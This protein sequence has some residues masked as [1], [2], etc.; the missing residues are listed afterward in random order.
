M[1][2]IS[3]SAHDLEVERDGALVIP[4]DLTREAL[5]EKLAQ[6]TPWGGWRHEFLFSNGLKVSDIEQAKPWSAEPLNKLKI[7]ESQ[8]DLERFRGGRALDVGCNVGYNS[9]YLSR[10]YGMRVK[11]IDVTRNQIDVCRFF[12]EQTRC[13]GAEFQIA[14]AERFFEDG[15]FDLVVHFGTLYHLKNPVLALENTSRNLRVGGLLLLETQC[16]GDADSRL[17]RYVRGFNDDITNWWAL[18]RGVI[19]DLLA[20]AGFGPSRL[21]FHWTAPIL[22]GM[23]RVII[24]AEKQ[25]PLEDVS[26]EGGWEGGQRPHL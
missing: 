9:I 17:A 12:A 13:E 11:G 22:D 7:A 1:T 18:G 10:K 2:G 19:D 14:D 15:V 25:R 5:K 24:A 23:S 8:V 21:L 26:A 16:H 6:L 3:S 4:T 20:Y